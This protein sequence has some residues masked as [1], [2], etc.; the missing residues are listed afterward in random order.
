MQTIFQA[1]M[2]F[3]L[4]AFAGGPTTPANGS[5]CPPSCCEP[6]C[7]ELP[8]DPCPPECCPVPCCGSGSC[9]AR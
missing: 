1:M 2:P 5:C 8:C 6:P 9:C 3:V 7:C 4:F